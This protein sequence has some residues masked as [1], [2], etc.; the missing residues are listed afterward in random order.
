LGDHNN[1]SESM[2]KSREI[3]QALGTRVLLGDWFAAAQAEVAFNLG[4]VDE[5]L[6]L[7]QKATEIAK[8]VGGVFAEGFAQRVWGQALAAQP[9]ANWAEVDTHIGESLRA[10]EIGE[11]V[12]EVARTR[13]VWVDLLS[14]RGDITAA[15]EQAEKAVIA[16][17]SSSL[18]DELANARTA[19]A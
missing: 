6:G 17:E 1:A 13:R 16:F 15:T 14:K 3:S 9:A 8:A 7:A 2:T 10:F 19:L 5:A 4:N 12:V 18:T 11:C